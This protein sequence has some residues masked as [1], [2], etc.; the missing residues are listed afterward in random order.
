MSFSEREGYKKPTSNPLESMGEILKNDIW[1][2][3][4][5]IINKDFIS[6]GNNSYDGTFYRNDS[7]EL[8]WAKFFNNNVSDLPYAGE[9]L[10]EI[11]DLYNDLE[12]NGVYDLIEFLLERIKLKQ[13]ITRTFNDVLEKNNASYTIINNIIQPISSKEVIEIMDTA[14]EGASS[15][16]KGHLDK[17]QKLYS[18][19]NDPDFDNSC[20]ESIKALEA[21]CQFVFKNSRIL[22][23]NI[24]K[25]KKEE[26]VNQHI[27]GVLEKI[28]AFRG[29]VTAH[30]KNPEGYSCDRDDA[31]L[32]HTLCCG[33]INYF[34]ATSNNN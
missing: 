21:Q 12:W 26:K 15:S 33:F 11:R 1:T 34:L 14:H 32:I 28:N 17:A 3:I 25:M 20:S 6:H 23:D 24:K 30:A 22:G 9:F 2:E 4:Y 16:S 13:K 8:V 19:K 7:A 27:I 18:K 31:I 10:K 5:G 29:D